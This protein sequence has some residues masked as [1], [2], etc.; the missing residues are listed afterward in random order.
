MSYLE[1]PVGQLAVEIPGA[2]AIFFKNKINFCCD[3]NKLLNEVVTQKK[4][5][6][7]YIVEALKQLNQRKE[8]TVNL[9]ELSNQE[10]ID[11]VLQRFH[12]VH[13]EQLC[14]LHRLAS[15]V[16]TV[17]KNHPL[18]P[19]GLA[20]HLALMEEEL[21]LHMKKEEAILFPLFA[22]NINSLL[23]ESIEVMK[24]EHEEH[25]SQIET[26][27]R[28]TNDVTPHEDACNTWRALYLGLQEFISDL[29]QHI[30]TEN[31][32]LFNRAIA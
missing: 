25:L 11:Y 18:C 21:S 19:T 10:V 30:H 3:G 12:E 27:Y 5:D 15:R 24:K 13:S 8:Q 29:N 22:R 31:N 23:G 1:W 4:L 26:I 17:H 20:Q 2:T 32:I 16:E 6:G 7:Q 9:Q 14:E 28:L